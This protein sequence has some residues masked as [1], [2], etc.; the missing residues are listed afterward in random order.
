MPDLTRASAIAFTDQLRLARHTALGDAEGFDEVIHVVERLGSYLTK[1]TVGDLGKIGGLKDYKGALAELAEKSGLAFCVPRE[2][3][4]LL[5][6]F[7]ELYDLVRVARNDAMHQGSFA[8]HLTVHAIELAIILED[9]LAQ[10]KDLRVSDFMVRNP[11]VAELW[12]PVGFIRQQMLVNSY[13]FLPVFRDGQWYL[14]SDAEIA[15]YLGAEREGQERR[16]RLAS[17]LE[18]EDVFSRCA[19]KKINLTPDSF[20]LEEALKTLSQE[21]VLLISGGSDQPLAGILTAFDLL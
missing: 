12:Q 10:H 2:Q 13:S 20:S 17:T 3:R 19:R 9:A 8:R 5:T 11:V 6:P 18:S 15:V 16:K 4:H 1:E 7:Y 21:S 14:I